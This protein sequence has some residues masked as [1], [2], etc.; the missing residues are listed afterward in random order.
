MGEQI[1]S[2][3]CVMVLTLLIGL[4]YMAVGQLDEGGEDEEDED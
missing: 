4:A 2:V 3:F 1:G